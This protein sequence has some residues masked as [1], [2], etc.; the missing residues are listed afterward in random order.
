ML[1]KPKKVLSS[2]PV[3][4]NLLEGLPFPKNTEV[5]VQLTA[6]GL[7]ITVPGAKKKY[8]IALDKIDLIS[9]TH[10]I[11]VQYVS[12]QSAP[13]MLMGGA[14]MGPVGAMVGGRVKSERRENYTFFLNIQYAQK[15][16]IIKPI[17]TNTLDAQKL[18][19]HFKN[20]KPMSAT[21]EEL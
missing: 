18:A 8:E 17:A 3:A 7:S 9:M 4:G 10:D 11:D 16:I 14:V 2:K 19:D 12:K 5:I 21:T 6:K 20:I 1:F 13:G 15:Q